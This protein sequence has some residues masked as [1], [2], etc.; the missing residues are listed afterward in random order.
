LSGPPTILWEKYLLPFTCC[1]VGVRHL[2][3]LDDGT[4]AGVDEY[5]TRIVGRAAANKSNGGVGPLVVLHMIVT[6]AT[7]QILWFFPH[8]FL[9][10]NDR[11]SSDR[12]S[13]SSLLEV[14]G[15]SAIPLSVPNAQGGGTHKMIVTTPSHAF[16][17]STL[18]DDHRFV[19]YSRSNGTIRMYNPRPA[20]SS[21]LPSSSSTASSSI[22]TSS[23][24]G[25]ANSDSATWTVHHEHAPWT[26]SSLSH[27]RELGGRRHFMPTTTCFAVSSKYIVSYS[28]SSMYSLA[29]IRVWLT[30]NGSLV[31][32]WYDTNVHHIGAIEANMEVATAT[33]SWLLYSVGS[34][35]NDDVLVVISSYLLD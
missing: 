9:T 12:K 3:A 11:Y 5:I 29:R 15:A 2:R 1:C 24:S 32:E 6:T 13:S 4:I 31:N 25:G 34:F 23:V 18:A 22:S 17:V 28:I 30:S 19:T 10:Y 33:M 16:R 20:A 7:P 14:K 8:W 26:F 35:L 27:P 21:S